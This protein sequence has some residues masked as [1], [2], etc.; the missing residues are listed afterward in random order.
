MS[1]AHYAEQVRLANST[2]YGSLN[3]PNKRFRI[4]TADNVV[5][6]MN[7]YVVAVQEHPEEL[8]ALFEQ[9]QEE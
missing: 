7:D 9:Q 3:D 8:H 2:F 4:K 1:I 6:A 5:R